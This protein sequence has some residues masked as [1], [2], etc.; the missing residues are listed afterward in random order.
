MSSIE[1]FTRW[2]LLDLYACAECGRCQDHC[3]AHLSG[4]TL[5][6]KTLMTKLKDH[7]DER[8]PELTRSEPTSAD[9][10]RPATTPRISTD[11]R[12]DL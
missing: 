5:S 4:K 3:P 7:L 6:P 10:H 1:G 11:R 8:G 2:Q 9:R 12:R